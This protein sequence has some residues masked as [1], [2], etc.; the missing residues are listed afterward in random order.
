MGFKIGQKVRIKS[1]AEIEKTLNAMDETKGIYFSHEGMD[2]FC[3]R[4]VTLKELSCSNGFFCNEVPWCWHSEWLEPLEESCTH[5]EKAVLIRGVS[6]SEVRRCLGHKAKSIEV[7]EVNR[8][9][10]D[11]LKEIDDRS[12][13]TAF[14]FHHYENTVIGCDK[15]GKFIG[16]A[17]RNPK[18][19]WNWDIACGLCKARAMKMKDL[20]KELLSML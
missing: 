3:G 17:R 15:S 13:K 18:D 8:T 10:E 20:E 1:L 7:I 12:I 2:K 4:A 5:R 9:I 16:I 11:I 19:D 6:E 14:C